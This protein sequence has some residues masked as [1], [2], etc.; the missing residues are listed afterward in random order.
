MNT[1]T[2]QVKQLLVGTPLEG[3]VSFA[4]TGVYCDYMCSFDMS[5]ELSEP[6]Y[7]WIKG[8]LVMLQKGNASGFRYLLP[9]DQHPKA[10]KIRAKQGWTP[11]FLCECVAE[12]SNS[13]KVK[14]YVRVQGKI[15]LLALDY[16]K[17]MVTERYR[18]VGNRIPHLVPKVDKKKDQTHFG[19]N[20]AYS[21]NYQYGSYEMNLSLNEA[22]IKVLEPKPIV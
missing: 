5:P 21:G 6:L 19:L 3:Q 1:I 2:E 17:V 7:E 10:D 22:Y 12:V 15:V 16:T 13:Y 14:V 4:Q 9:Q 8:H 20:G 11:T 18:P